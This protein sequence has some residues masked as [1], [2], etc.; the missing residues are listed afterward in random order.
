MEIIKGNMFFSFMPARKMAARKAVMF[1]LCTHIYVLSI[2]LQCGIFNGNNTDLTKNIFSTVGFIDC[3]KLLRYQNRLCHRTEKSIHTSTLFLF[4]IRACGDIEVNP[5]P[6]Q[7][8]KGFSIYQQNLRGLW[9][10]KEVLE[11][12]INQKNIKIFA[13]TETLLL[14][15]TPNSFLQIRG[16]TSERKDRTKAGG[17]I[18]GYIKEGITYL[19][20][21]DLECDEIEAIWLEIMVERGNSFLIGIMYGHPNT[22]KHL[23]KNFEQKLANILNNISLLNKETIIL[24]DL[25][26]NYLD[27]KSNVSIKDFSNYAAINKSLKLQLGSQKTHQLLLT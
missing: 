20:Q 16:Y 10:N 26:C 25:N 11:H 7:A 14:S 23:H 1:V 3:I 21:S 4:L 22:S 24:E 6:E 9:N 19:P 13:I 17:G 27:N 18:A 15:S 5:G 2:K 12:I 8:D